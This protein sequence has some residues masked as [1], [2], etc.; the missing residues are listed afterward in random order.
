MFVVSELEDIMLYN[1]LP[2]SKS[3]STTLRV[4]Y[5]PSISISANLDQGFIDE[6]LDMIEAKYSLARPSKSSV[7][8]YSNGNIKLMS[9]KCGKI[10]KLG[11]QKGSKSKKK[12]IC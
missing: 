5:K 12:I 10:K 7:D 8:Q 2:G 9:K 4:D 6:A 3:K 1:Q 11:T